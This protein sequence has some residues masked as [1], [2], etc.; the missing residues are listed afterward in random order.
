MQGIMI[1][2]RTSPKGMIK[3]TTSIVT[4]DITSCVAS[5]LMVAAGKVIFKWIPRIQNLGVRGG[6]PVLPFNRGASRMDAAPKSGCGC[7]GSTSLTGRTTP[8]G[9]ISAGI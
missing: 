9:L 1:G 2:A 8:S 7:N 4:T 6:A 3:P 5:A